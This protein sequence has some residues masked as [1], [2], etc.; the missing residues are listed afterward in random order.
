[1]ASRTI[2]NVAAELLPRNASRKSFVI[3][4]EDSTD[5]AYIKLERAENTTV[6]ATDHDFRLG[7]GASLALNAS[8]DGIQAITSR[9]TAI[10]SANT[11]RLSYFET[12]DIVR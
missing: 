8:T 3:Q 4:N 6:S 9:I 1:M 10:A 5:I 2:S 12:E 7:P 11:P